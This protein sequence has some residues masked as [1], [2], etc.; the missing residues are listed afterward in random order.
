[1]KFLMFVKPLPDPES[2]LHFKYRDTAAAH[3]TPKMGMN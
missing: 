3:T 1:M 2:V